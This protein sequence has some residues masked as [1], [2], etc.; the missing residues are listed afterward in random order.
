MIVDLPERFSM[1]GVAVIENGILKIMRYI[2]FSDIMYELTYQMK[3]RNICGYCKKEKEIK[4]MTLDHMYPQ[5]LGGPTITNNLI[6]CCK[7]CNR[8][9]GNLTAKEFREYSK[10]K[11][12]KKTQYLKKVQRHQE[13]L[14]RNRKYHIPIDWIEER[15]VSDLIL[16]WIPNYSDN[17]Y[18]KEK[19]YYEE[20]GMFKKIVIIDRNNQI[21]S[22]ALSYVIAKKMKLKTIPVIFLENVEFIELTV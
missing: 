18:K 7:K 20:T 10:K 12:D 14:K 8:I 22:G 15:N 13:K 19:R 9:K 1:E 3:G 21:L 2:A 11:Q 5:D 16:I 6:P 4:K 17:R